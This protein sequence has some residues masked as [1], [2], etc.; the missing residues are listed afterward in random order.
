MSKEKFFNKYGGWALITG[1]TSGIGKDFALELARKGFSLHIV[2]RSK[3]SLIAMKK[4]IESKEKITVKYSALDLSMEEN[5]KLLISE[6]ETLDIGLLVLAAGYG[7]G[8]KFTELPR[9]PE[10]N[11]IDLNCRSVVQLTHHFV[12]KF[13][14][15]QKGGIILFGSLVGFQGVAWASTYAATKAFIQSF[16]E[17][18]YEEL[19]SIG[20]DILSVAPGPIKSGFGERAN[21]NMGMS[22][23]PIGIANLSLASLGNQPTVRPGLLSKFLGY[24]LILLPR[25]LRSLILKQIMAEMVFNKKS[26]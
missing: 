5:V 4:E 25:R 12:N 17:G 18:L 9:E 24:S 23:S 15:K 8:G 22:Q 6:T 7:T 11:Q 2:A 13:K 14:Q 21:M 16:A 1:A 26:K 10:L 19:K 3:D 20:I